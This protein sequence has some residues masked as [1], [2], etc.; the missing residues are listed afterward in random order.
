MWT[1]AQQRVGAL[2]KLGLQ[3]DP[4]FERTWP[5]VLGTLLKP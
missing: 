5:A 1:E 2:L 4:D 3:R